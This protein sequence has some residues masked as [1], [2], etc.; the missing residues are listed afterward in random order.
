MHLPLKE[1]NEAEYWTSLLR[2]S[3]YM[4]ENVASELLTNNAEI[5]R[6]LI[7]SINTSKRNLKH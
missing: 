2:D 3:M 5:S 6:L 1:S 7:S 4:P